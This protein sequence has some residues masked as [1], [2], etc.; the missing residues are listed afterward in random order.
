MSASV[1]DDIVTFTIEVPKIAQASNVQTDS[2]LFV[3]ANKVIVCVRSNCTS[4]VFHQFSCAPPSQSSD[5]LTVDTLNKRISS[6]YP[7]SRHLVNRQPPRLV[8]RTLFRDGVALL[9]DAKIEAGV[10]SSIRSWKAHQYN[11]NN[12]NCAIFHLQ[13]G[14][15][16]VHCVLSGEQGRTMSAACHNAFQRWVE[17]AQHGTLD[18]FRVQLINTRLFIDARYGLCWRHDTIM[19][20]MLVCYHARPIQ[21]SG[22]VRHIAAFLSLP[23]SSVGFGDDDVEGLLSGRDVEGRTYF[24]RDSDDDAMRITFEPTD[25]TITGLV[26]VSAPFLAQIKD[27][28]A[29]TGLKGYHHDWLAYIPNPGNNNDN[30]QGAK[31]QYSQSVYFS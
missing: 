9:G 2:D 7:K 4:E 24:H 13:R 25:R 16:G 15:D 20:V 1:G 8:E 22:I 17:R 12:N 31:K 26:R 6:R 19:S 14:T 18:P 29:A 5:T 28:D 21:A 23:L 27:V 3:D 30:N 10:Y 11:N